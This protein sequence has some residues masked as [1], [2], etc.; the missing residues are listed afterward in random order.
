M[1][2]NTR[3]FHCVISCQRCYYLQKSISMNGTSR[4]YENVQWKSWK[5]TLL[6]DILRHYPS[7]EAQYQEKY[8]KLQYPNQHF[9]HKPHIRCTGR[10]ICKLFLDKWR[11]CNWKMITKE[12]NRYICTKDATFKIHQCSQVACMRQGNLYFRNGH[13]VQDL[14]ST[15]L[16]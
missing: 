6:Q 13:F 7:N 3:M 10:G 12:R 14:Y 16:F 4:W 11:L 8:L 2:S 5:R 15:Y 9:K 1:A